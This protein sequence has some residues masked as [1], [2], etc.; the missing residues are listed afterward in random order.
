MIDP[1]RALLRFY[2]STNDRDGQQQIEL[3]PAKIDFSQV[4]DFSN[5]TLLN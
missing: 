1:I 4:A 3:K 5:F 2:D